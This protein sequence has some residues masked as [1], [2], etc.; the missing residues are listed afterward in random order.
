MTEIDRA[1]K[2]LRA[3]YDRA[4]ALDYVQFPL[5]Y[6]LYKTWIWA[7]EKNKDTQRKREKTE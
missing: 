1:I 4:K 3:E 7:D 5:G 6:A 2:H